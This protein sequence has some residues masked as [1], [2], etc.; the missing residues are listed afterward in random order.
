MG[1]IVISQA[2]EEEEIREVF[3]IR[4]E[5][6]VD[7]Q[8]VFSDSDI[9]EN[10]QKSIYL[11]AREDGRIVGTVRVFPSGND[12]TWVGGRLAVKS[13][14]RGNHAAVLLSREAVETV[15]AHNCRRFIAEIQKQNVNFF[16]QLG[17]KLIGDEFIYS[18]IPHQLMEA[19]LNISGRRD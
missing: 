10:D 2:V 5:V 9:D 3:A 17:W 6:F 12:G 15:K 11:I 16:R 7:E 4:K 1:H 13:E 18:G 19:D 14:Y 8:K